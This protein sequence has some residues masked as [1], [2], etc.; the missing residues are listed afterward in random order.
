MDVTSSA[1]P[2]ARASACIR[3]RQS[4]Q[5]LA[6]RL[7]VSRKL[8]AQ[9]FVYSTLVTKIRPGSPLPRGQQQDVKLCWISAFWLCMISFRLNYWR[10]MITNAI[11]LTAML[12]F[13]LRGSGDCN[14]SL[15]KKRCLR[16]AA[17]L[18]TRCWLFRLSLFKLATQVQCA[19]KLKGL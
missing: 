13:P 17:G 8:N 10:W 12:I 6:P 9:P 1:F 2:R 18:I 4:S 19:G 11:H 5:L 3:A 7:C 16:R 14:Q 15:N